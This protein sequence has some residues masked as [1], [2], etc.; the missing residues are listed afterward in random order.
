MTTRLGK[1]ENSYVEQL[2]KLYEE[3]P[4]AVFAAIAI[5]AL[6]G[7]GDRL[8]EAVVAICT[9]WNILHQNGIV[10]QKAPSAKRILGIE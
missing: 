4:K 7:G 3:T 9:E 1:L 6:T 10:P 5:S 8:D 2:G